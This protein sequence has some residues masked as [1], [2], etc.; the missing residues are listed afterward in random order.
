M[1]QQALVVVQNDSRISVPPSSM[2]DATL[3]SV[4]SCCPCSN[5]P[6]YCAMPPFAPN[7]SEEGMGQQQESSF[8]VFYRPFLI[9]PCAPSI[10]VCGASTCQASPDGTV[11]TSIVS[12][13][14]ATAVTAGSS[15]ELVGSHIL[16]NFAVTLH[17][18]GSLHGCTT[19]MRRALRTY[20]VL[21]GILRNKE[22]TDVS[23]NC[24]CPR[25]SRVDYSTGIRKTTLQCLAYNN[26]AHIYFEHCLYV[27]SRRCVHSMLSSLHTMKNCS[28]RHGDEAFF[29][30][31][32]ELSDLLWNANSVQ[33]PTLA[34]AA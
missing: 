4:A 30:H 7:A 13:T 21:I 17:R 18:H 33:E 1:F 28:R 23:S 8:F 5:V 12:S 9:F 2:M 24:G 19:S 25:C 26:L 15:L 27:Q 3:T 16:F 31:P 32:D 34:S 22:D 20:Q 10:D 29:L 14:T 6:S 11:D